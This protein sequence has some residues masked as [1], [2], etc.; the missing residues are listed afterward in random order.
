MNN[1]NSNGV[2][3]KMANSIENCD[4]ETGVCT[5]GKL[6]S[7]KAVVKTPEDAKIIYVGDPMCS[8][9]WGIAPQ[10]K[11]LKEHYGVDNFEVVVGGL[12]PGGGDP[13]NDQM[14]DFLSHHW[15]QVHEKSGQPFSYDLM[16]RKSF[17]Y[18]TEPS[19]RA[20]VVARNWLG[21]DIMPFFEAVQYKFYAQSED[22][23]ELSFYQSICDQLAIPFE[24]FSE[25]FESQDAVNKTHEE[26][27]LNRNWGV[28]GY[29]TVLVEKEKKLYV[30]ARGY[31]EFETMKSLIDQII[32]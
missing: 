29:P 11:K 23:N 2:V 26:F 10:L 6:T 4:P 27:M 3:V 19:C 30:V 7:D 13:W 24:A 20:V 14:K 28:T 15:Q 31:S 17:N 8:W 21:H 25:K 12:R 18:D 22:P 1:L 32:T 5:P 16:D 9:C